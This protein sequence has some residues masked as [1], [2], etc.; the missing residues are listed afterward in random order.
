MLA[1]VVVKIDRE[2]TP[3]DFSDGSTSYGGALITCKY[4]AR[5][6]VASLRG[7]MAHEL[8]H[9]LFYDYQRRTSPAAQERDAARDVVARALDRLRRN[10]QTG[11]EWEQHLT[12]DEKVACRIE[13]IH[14]TVILPYHE[15]VADLIAVAVL[16]TP[17]PNRRDFSTMGTDTDGATYDAH[18]QFNPT[19]ASLWRSFL[20]DQLDS[21]RACAGLLE[22]VAQAC[23]EEIQAVYE[24][25]EA[26]YFG[27]GDL[28]ARL[29]RRSMDMPS[30][31]ALNERLIQRIERALQARKRSAVPA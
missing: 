7:A 23:N 28:D 16:K 15:L 13:Q 21:A 3:S 20:R 25:A 8:G 1:P 29:D 31:K 19:R 2:A 30:A 24:H 12:R 9:S 10:G 11:R 18:T 27:L 22:I 5:G 26:A 4:S 17:K 6:G 14:R